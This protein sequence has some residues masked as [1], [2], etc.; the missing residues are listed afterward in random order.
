[1]GRYNGAPLTIA[2]TGTLNQKGLLTAWNDAKGFGFITPEGGGERVFAH[3]SCYAGRG[4]CA[5]FF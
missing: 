5:G 2:G 3:I 1:M 4:C